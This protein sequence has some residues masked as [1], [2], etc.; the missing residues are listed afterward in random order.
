VTSLKFISSCPAFAL[1]KGQFEFP[2]DSKSKEGEKTGNV[3]LERSRQILEE[4]TIQGTVPFPGRK[5][6]SETGNR[7]ESDIHK[8][9]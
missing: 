1:G 6:N 3:S 7:L 5:Q 2:S 9:V 4:T 8:D